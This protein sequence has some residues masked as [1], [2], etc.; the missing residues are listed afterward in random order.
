MVLD[1]L[2]V[3]CFDVNFDGTYRLNEELKL[4]DKTNDVVG[5]CTINIPRCYVDK[6]TKDLVILPELYEELNEKQTN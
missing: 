3:K 1:N 4:Y 6:V 5:I 2:T